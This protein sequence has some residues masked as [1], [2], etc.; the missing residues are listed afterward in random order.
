MV[1]SSHMI[2]IGWWIIRPGRS[3]DTALIDYVDDT[4]NDGQ[5]DQITKYGAGFLSVSAMIKT[6]CT[7]N[8]HVLTLNAPIATKVVR[9]SRLLKCLRS[10]YSKQGGPRSDCSYRGSLFWVHTVCFYT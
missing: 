5:I 4:R 7:E 9:F 2:I 8:V 6:D 1:V 3:G 10:L